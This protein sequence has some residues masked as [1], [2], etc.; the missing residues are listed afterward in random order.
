MS[1][2]LVAIKFNHDPSSATADA[3]SIRRNASTPVTVPEWRQS[4]SV[5]HADSP[6]AYAASEIGN[7]TVTIKVK[8]RR[9]S[10]NVSSVE[11]RAVDADAQ[12]DPP[13]GC[14]GVFLWLLDA[15]I[16]AALSNVNV[17]GNVRPRAVAFMT[18]GD[19]TAFE[20]FELTGRPRG[21]VRADTVTWRWQYRLGVSGTWQDFETTRHTI[22]TLLEPPKAPWVQSADPADTQLPWTEVLDYACWWARL[23]GDRDTAA[24]LI[25]QRVYALGPAPV[26]YDCPGGGSTRYAYPHF[27]CTSFL[28]RLRGGPGRG[29]YVNCTDCATIVSTF[30]N[31]VGCDLWQS[32]IGGDW[33]DLNPILSIGASAWLRACD[34]GGFSYHEVAWKGACTSNDQIFDACLKVDG[35][36]D[37]TAA[38]HTPLLPV[39]VRF[40]NTGDGDYR[41]RLATPRGRRTCNPVP[42]SRTRRR[43][44]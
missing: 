2:Q 18:A 9:T 8:L 42:S 41:D 44:V 21:G 37:P 38:P 4:V 6:A 1:V 34:W 23:A 25:T 17:L 5:T 39:N 43:V 20:T 12:P 19:E 15:I 7:N 16:R 28:E 3:L 22:Y 36:A 33:F 32:R 35:D 26:E 29:R 10:P 14:R 27:F 13:A 40:G 31:A 30:A 24:G 11:V